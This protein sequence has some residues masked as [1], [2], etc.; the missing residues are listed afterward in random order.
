M[1]EFDR[2]YDLMGAAL[3]DARAEIERLNKIIETEAL[4]YALQH[5]TI[6]RLTLE[7]GKIANTLGADNL[8]L[9]AALKQLVKDIEDGFPRDEGFD[10]ANK[11]LNEQLATEEK[12][13]TRP[14]YK[15]W[16]DADKQDRNVTIERCAQVVDE[17]AKAECYPEQLVNLAAAIRKLKD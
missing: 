1:D 5:D 9:R 14:Q 6:E 3:R 7:N 15:T 17:E 4:N 10:A 16:E 13:M 8:R 2:K 11:I 12:S